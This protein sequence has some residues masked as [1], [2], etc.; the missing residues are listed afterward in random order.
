MH[1][2]ALLFDLD[3]TLADTHS[4]LHATMNVI[5]ERYG[6]PSVATDRVR[7]MIGGGARAILQRGF[8]VHDFSVSDAQ[9]DEATEQFVDY[10]DQHID[11]FTSVFDGVRE[12]LENAKRQNM[13]LAVITNKRE[14]LAAKLLFRLDLH[15]FF[16]LLIGGDTLAA[17][18]PDPL[19][20]TTALER[21][22]VDAARAIMLGDSEA[23]TESA[24]AA[25]V[26][27][28]CVSFGYRRVSLEELGADAIIDSYS[29]LPAAIEA[30][31]G[32][33]LPSLRS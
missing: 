20:I 10:Y 21:L 9:L 28:I 18:K 6:C 14:S 31:K 27:C 11:D 8:A 32:D 2:S 3:G 15:Q 22:G 1:P 26:A 5:L 4:D 7:H 33:S 25:Q 16:D 19:P 17:R 13:R 23:D 30:L 29:E 24:R 12:I